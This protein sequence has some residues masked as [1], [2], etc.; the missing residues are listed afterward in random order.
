MFVFFG[1]LFVLALLAALVGPYF[2]D[3][4]GYRSD[5]E[6]EV[7]RI[8]GR[9]VTVEG[10]VTAR[11]LPFPSVSFTDVHVAGETETSPAMTVEEFSMDAE[12][13]PFMRGEIL[14]FDMR[15]VR[16]K[17]T[18]RIGA[19]GQVDWAVRPSSRFDPN[20]IRL[21][22]VRVVEGKVTLLHEASGRQHTLTEINADLSADSLAGPWRVD[23]SLRLDG[24]LTD[25]S[26]STGTANPDGTMRVR[27]RADP[28]RYPVAFEADGSAQF[29]PDSP[30]YSGTFHLDAD[31]RDK[32]VLRGSD[33]ETFVASG[34]AGQDAGADYRFA[35]RFQL[36]HKR[37]DIPEFRLE[38]GPRE[39]PYTADG[40][41]LFDFGATPRF[42]IQA[43][44]A[45]VRFDEAIGKGNEYSG[46][47]LEDRFEGLK[48]ALENLPR[49]AIKGTLDID[50]PAVVAGDTTI[51]NVRLSAEPSEGGWAVNTLSALLPGRTTLEASG[52]LRSGEEDFGFKGKLL[53]AVAQ[54][55][56]FAAWA[57]RDVDDAIR[58]LPAAGF[59][60]DVELDEKRQLFR[61][62]ELILGDA[63]FH[64]LLERLTREG[65]RPAII[66]RLNG[67]ALDVQGMT[68]FASLFVSDAGVTHFGNHDVDFDLEAGPVSLAGL[69]ADKVST[70]MR[71]REDHLEIDRLAIA[72][73]AGANISATGTIQ[74]ID[75]EPSGSLDAS[76]L[77]ADLGP[78]LTLLADRFPANPFAAA[79]AERAAAFP[80]M[81]ADAQIDLVANLDRADGAP[82]ISL[83]AQGHTGANDFAFSGA[84]TGF[85]DGLE[86]GELAVELS[87]DSTDTAQLLALY[88]LPANDLGMTSEGTTAFSLNGKVADGARLTFEI[89]SPEAQASFDGSLRAAEGEGGLAADGNL[90]LSGSDF[91]PWMI[92]AGFALPG[93]GLGMPADLKADATLVPG[94]LRLTKI[95][96][97]IAD[98]AVAGNLDGS[99]DQDVPVVDGKLTLGGFDLDHAVALVLGE[100]ALQSDG[101]GWPDTPFVET[102]SLAVRGQIELEFDTLD[103]GNFAAAENVHMTARLDAEGLALSGI[104]ADALGGKAEGLVEL[105]NN[106]GTGLL[107]AQMSLKDANAARVLGASGIDGRMDASAAVT[108]SGKSVSGMVASLAG[109]GTAHVENLVVP[110]VDPGAFAAIIKGADEIGREID[111]AKVAGYAPDV[112]GRGSFAAQEVDVP[113]TVAAGVL[114]TPPIYLETEGARLEVEVKADLAAND[115][116]VDGSIGYAEGDEALAGSEPVVNIAV[117]GS[118]GDTTR[119]FDTEP[120][121]QFLTQRALEREQARVEAMQ[122]GL[123]EKQR[124]RRETRYFVQ[125]AELREVEKERTER[126]RIAEE[127][128]LKSEAEATSLQA[129]E[130]ARREAEAQAAREAEAKARAEEQKR[131]EA[132]EAKKAAAEE[133]AK[134]KAEEEAKAKAA[135]EKRRQAEEAKKAADE[136]ARIEAQKAA[137]MEAAAEETTVG[138]V[139]R[140]TPLPGTAPQG[141]SPAMFDPDAI[142]NLLRKTPEQP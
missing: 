8:L 71:L 127:A 84:A 42:L 123:L 37:L 80:A 85:E 114:R 79:A 91:E 35:G 45:Q 10:D 22:K 125:Q 106:G 14:I 121:A 140:R 129:A 1:G 104:S 107:S 32:T 63:R 38:T 97:T 62:V 130:E 65:V 116:A 29:K 83:H 142:R 136:A 126:E 99:W 58:R 102:L 111:A 78:F 26:V 67:D 110:G 54:P 34:Q 5:F 46:A 60:A 112:L 15:L 16:P 87:A 17:A 48:T 131:I 92:T 57:A 27:L 72:G 11:L 75:A 89:A 30:L 86:Q 108:A 53:L 96:G 81:M 52:Y 12:L 6:R 120:L 31:N 122:A 88:G 24:M 119:R 124:L 61:N 134:R 41:A 70:A 113:F 105:R 77:A 141:S 139:I 56:G 90:L 18:I 2:V 101:E 28:E 66:A 138:D 47:T 137:R 59:S 21:E 51:R 135:E 98:V 9:D 117:T 23:G 74:D 25:V 73:L 133:A 115:I 64:G 19:D 36:D 132:E 44:G 109:S 40:T 68:A 3:W 118:Y 103:I 55:S 20:Q 76:V 128:R 69:S 50:L 43:T 95:G 4:T 13:A 93:M 49:P 100:T 7:S 82:E 94:Q 39:D 33:G